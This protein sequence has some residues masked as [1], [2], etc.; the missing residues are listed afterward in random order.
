MIQIL[1]QGLV[2]R[3][4]H[5]NLRAI[6]AWHPS[7]VL[8]NDGSML[9]GFDL[10]QAV[11]AMDYKTWI[12]RS[13]DQGKTWDAPRLLFNEAISRPCIYS[14]RL[15]GVKDGSIVG[16]GARYYRDDP[17]EGVVNRAN[18]GYVPMDLILLRS[19]DGGVTWDGPKTIQPP[20]V[21][22][23]FEICHKII[24][25][26]DGRWL[27]PTATWKGWNGEAPNGMK[28][29]A[30]V[31]R[32]EGRTWPEWI[33]II[34]Q[35]DRGVI[36]WEQGLTEL[37]DGRLLAVVWSF[38]EKSGKSLPNRYAISAD[39]R[40]FSPPRENG[41]RGETAKLHTLPDGRVLCL[42]RRLDKP[43]LWANVVKIDGD[44]WVNLAEMPLWQGPASGMKGER[45]A[46]EELGAL[47]FGFPS[48]A[49]LPDG[50]IFAVF[51]CVEECI[52]NI[53][54]VKLKIN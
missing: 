44:N 13:R 46:G 45:S 14:V 17:E 54:W 12:S 2:Y 37:P 5:P 28:A 35:Y 29:I 49:Q 15:S 52:H 36:S 31:S 3:N 40:F 53:R 27:A 50:S 21:G 34:D 6:H 39:G 7:I 9:A 25:L 47:K 32:D 19:R 8:L 10:A 30:L 43:G 33:T 42:Y 41:M 11:E 48:M 20:L 24:E 16:F 51:W 4:P 26:R 1:D 22:P 38:D 18:L 23:G